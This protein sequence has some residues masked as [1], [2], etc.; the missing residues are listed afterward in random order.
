MGGLIDSD[1]LLQQFAATETDRSFAPRE[2][3][4]GI[5]S[6]KSLHL[7]LYSGD[8]LVAY[9]T[10]TSP[11]PI[12]ERRKAEIRALLAPLTS[13]LHASRN[14][15][16]AVTDELSGLSSRRYFE[17]RLQEEWARHVR[18]GAPV[19]V[20]CFDLDHFKQLNDTLGHGAGDLAIRRFGE[21]LSRHGPRQ[22]PRLPPWRRR[23]R[24]PLPGDVRPGRPGR[25]RPRAADR[26]AGALSRARA[27]RF[28][29]PCPR[30][31]PT[32][33]ALA[34][35][36]RHQLLFRADQALYLAKESGRNRT[37]LWSD[38]SRMRGMT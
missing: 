16:I 20:A 24:R 36:N 19:A 5:P 28:G 8:I 3:L 35:E 22:R 32:P 37:R 38:R 12:E 31:S 25:R 29:S 10:L 2:L 13:S 6:T 15:E 21:I 17:T 9:L 4:P 11:E 14:W 34:A 26:R 18:Y 23:V 30:G 1:A 27:G 7:P 33:S